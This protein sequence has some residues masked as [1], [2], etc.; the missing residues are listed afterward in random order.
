M[1]TGAPAGKN[2]RDPKSEIQHPPQLTEEVIKQANLGDLD[3][4]IATIRHPRPES[5]WRG[6]SQHTLAHVTGVILVAGLAIGY[7][8]LKQSSAEKA[9]PANDCRPTY[10]AES[11]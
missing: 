4:L 6:F 3:E 2:D 10:L 11:R 5:W 1:S 7:G 8:M 9:A